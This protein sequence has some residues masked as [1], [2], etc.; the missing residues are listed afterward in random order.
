MTRF[1]RVFAV[2]AAV[3]SMAGCK[4]PTPTTELA[5]TVDDDCA[6]S[7]QVGTAAD[8]RCEG[9]TGVCYCRTDTACG[10]REFCNTVGF[11]Q[12]RVGCARNSDCLGS[13]LFCDTGTGTC[14]SEGRCTHDLH[15]RIGQVCDT[16]R[17]LCAEGCRS[18]GDCNDTSCRCD[19]GPCN[20]TGTT[21]AERAACE[22]GV[23]D[24]AFCESEAYCRYG[25]KCG[26]VGDGGLDQQQCFNDYDPERRPYCN[27]CT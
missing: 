6:K 16:A 24:P 19:G 11:C 5:C 3:L 18:G 21:E 4:D 15:C 23:C 2:L 12:D 9:S 10:P 26:V 14:L 25:E 20:C 17:R 22:I 7:L 13:G 27:Q 1:A 8:H